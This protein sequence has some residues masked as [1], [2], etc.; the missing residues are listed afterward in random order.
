M[1]LKQQI[2]SYFFIYEGNDSKYVYTAY[3]VQSWGQI[4]MSQP[5]QHKIFVITFSCPVGN[6]NVTTNDVLALL[7]HF[8]I[9]TGY[10]DVTTKSHLSLEQ[11][12]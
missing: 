9:L 6:K 2:V 7:S 8:P 4:S 1:D 11:D 5:L 3:S 10:K 12:K